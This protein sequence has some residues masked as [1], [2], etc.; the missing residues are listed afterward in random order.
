MKGKE[1]VGSFFGIVLLS[2]LIF[3]YLFRD[4]DL[5]YKLSTIEY[6]LDRASIN[7]STRVCIFGLNFGDEIVDTEVSIKDFEKYKKNDTYI[8]EYAV[9][10]NKTFLTLAIICW[11]ICIVLLIVFFVD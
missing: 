9:R 6:K 5:V 4:V 3:I 7:G 10:Q 8:Y 11:F 1:I 2:S